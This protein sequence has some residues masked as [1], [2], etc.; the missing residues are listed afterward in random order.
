M[1]ESIS[2]SFSWEHG[3][4]WSV[5]WAECTFNVGSSTWM[6]LSDKVLYYA[7]AFCL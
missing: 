1:T 6:D 5:G 4:S 7:R 3:I 2:V